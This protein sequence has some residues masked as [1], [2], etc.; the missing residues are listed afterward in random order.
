MLLIVRE[1]LRTNSICSS[2][3]FP[4]STVAHFL[5]QADSLTPRIGLVIGT[6]CSFLS[7]HKSGDHIDGAANM[8]LKWLSQ[9]LQGLGGKSE[10]Y[11]SCLSK[12]KTSEPSN[13]PEIAQNG[14]D[15]LSRLIPTYIGTLLT[16]EPSSLEFLF[17]FILKALTGSDPLPKI[18]AADFWVC[19]N[20]K[21]YERH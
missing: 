16:T 9:L 17:V 11:I 14:I 10:S 4:A 8:L 6:A 7:S 15:F 2:Q 18:A 5:I 19:T 1:T 12:L 21:I 13:D 3:V 20:L